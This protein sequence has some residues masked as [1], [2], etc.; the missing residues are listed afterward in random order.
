[1]YILCTNDGRQGVHNIYQTPLRIQSKRLTRNI[2]L[3]VHRAL[4][5]I[6]TYAC[7]VRAFAVDTHGVELQPVQNMAPRS[8]GKCPERALTRELHVAFTV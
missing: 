6:L 3:T 4:D 2:K 7:A 8:T 1:M 5:S